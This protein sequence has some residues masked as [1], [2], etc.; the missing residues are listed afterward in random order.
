M[1][2][3]MLQTLPKRKQ[4]NDYTFH[5]YMIPR[6][7]LWPKLPIIKSLGLWEV[8]AE[9]CGFACPNVVVI[10]SKLEKT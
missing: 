8:F 2:A 10:S 1:F 3:H 7:F 4:F 5:N 9:T 6:N